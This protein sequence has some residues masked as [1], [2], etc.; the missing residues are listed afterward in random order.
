M[1]EL[2][3][4]PW[5]LAL[6]LVAGMLGAMAGLG[7]SLFVLPG[8]AL[9]LGYATEAH[10]EQHLYTAAAMC[11]NFAVAV[12]ATIAYAAAGRLDDARAQ[13]DVA[14]RFAARWPGPAWPAA[15]TEAAAVV[16]RA[17]GREDDAVALFGRAASG[18]DLAAQPLDAARC[19]EAV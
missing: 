12:P 6:G 4:M 13:L 11:V 15:A 5:L 16:A 1:P 3:H 18:F 7:G 9:I 17:E 8:L 10:S 19:R 2:I 14:Q